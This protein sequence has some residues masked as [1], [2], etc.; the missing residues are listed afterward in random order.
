VTL[1]DSSL[2]GRPHLAPPG[3]AHLLNSGHLS[4][5]VPTPG[6]IGAVQDTVGHAVAACSGMVPHTARRQHEEEEKQTEQ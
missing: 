2:D 5:V 4:T 1:L 6:T 3:S